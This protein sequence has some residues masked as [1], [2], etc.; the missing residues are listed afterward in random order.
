MTALGT[1]LRLTAG[2]AAVVAQ[3]KSVAVTVNEPIRL[4]G[5]VLAPGRYQFQTFAHNSYLRISGAGGFRMNVQTT[6]ISRVNRGEVLALR[7][8]VAGSIAE[9]ATW[10]PGGGTSGYEFAAHSGN[11]K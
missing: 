9:L 3:E 1:F 10:Y 4:P 7:S 5:G 11:A 8:R 6:P 2:P